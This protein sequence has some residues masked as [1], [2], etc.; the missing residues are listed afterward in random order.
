MGASFYSE[1]ASEVLVHDQVRGVLLF[2]LFEN[3]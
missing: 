3:G 1:G 2:V